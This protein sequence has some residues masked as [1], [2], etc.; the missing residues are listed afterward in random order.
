MP[1]LTQHLRTHRREK[2]FACQDCGRRFHQ[3][4]KLI[5]HQRVHS[6]E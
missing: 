2:P 6:A 3:S 1:T 5:Q 4:T